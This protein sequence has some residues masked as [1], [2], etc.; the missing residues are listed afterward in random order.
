MTENGGE[1]AGLEQ[2]SPLI[3]VWAGRLY[4]FYLYCSFTDSD[5]FS[6][7]HGVAI[8]FYLAR[9][10]EWVFISPLDYSFNNFQ[11]S[12]LKETRFWEYYCKVI[13][14]GEGLFFFFSVKNRIL[15]GTIYYG[16]RLLLVDGKEINM[17]PPSQLSLIPDGAGKSDL[18]LSIFLGNSPSSSLQPAGGGWAHICQKSGYLQST[19]LIHCSVRILH[20]FS[21]CFPALYLP[22]LLV[23]CCYQII[24]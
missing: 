13:Y 3:R 14:W 22:N 5:F 2:H 21:C 23:Y 6:T 10:M 1:G 9:K 7:T 16:W 15:V 12:N 24:L 18:L 8:S 4:W 11:P 20:F 19:H 17:P